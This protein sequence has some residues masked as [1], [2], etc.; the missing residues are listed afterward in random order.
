LIFTSTLAADE[1][2]ESLAFSISP[3]HFRITQDHGQQDE[4]DFGLFLS[5]SIAIPTEA[6]APALPLKTMASACSLR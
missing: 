3:E 2:A 5:S 1:V 4:G 6:A